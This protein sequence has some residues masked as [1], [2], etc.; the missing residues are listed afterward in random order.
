MSVIPFPRWAL[1]YMAA[2]GALAGQDSVPPAPATGQGIRSQFEIG[3]GRTIPTGD[4]NAD[5]SGNGF[6]GGWTGTA[7]VTLKAPQSALG[8]RIDAAYSANSANT[9][10]KNHLTT[11]FGTPSDETITLIDLNAALTYVFAPRARVTPSLFGGVGAY[12]VTIGVTSGGTTAHSSTTRLAWHVGGELR[13]RALFLEVRYVAV[14]AVTGL[15][16]TT[17]FP[18]TAGV[19]FGRGTAH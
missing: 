3:A 12:L 10:L 15:H 9:Q 7:R 4:F 16:Q 17:F 2:A 11:A 19:Q 5:T 6:D 8:L 18:I 1:A 13:Y 14:A